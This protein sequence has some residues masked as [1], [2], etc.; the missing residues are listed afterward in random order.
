VD[1][2]AKTGMA[3]ISKVKEFYGENP[4]IAFTTKAGTISAAQT[5]DCLIGITGS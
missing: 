2:L 4:E 3:F 1:R 5:V